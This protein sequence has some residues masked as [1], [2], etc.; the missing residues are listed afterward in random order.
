MEQI[1]NSLTL[2]ASI[3]VGAHIV[4]QFVEKW[5]R[6]GDITAMHLS[7]FDQDKIDEY[8]KHPIHLLQR[9]CSRPYQHW[10]V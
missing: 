7:E 9:L 8:K 1:I 2:P 3:A 5:R 4:G 6:M 10:Q